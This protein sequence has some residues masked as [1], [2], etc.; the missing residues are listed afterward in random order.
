VKEVQGFRDLKVKK[1][2][3]VFFLSFLQKKKCFLFFKKWVLIDFFFETK[4]KKTLFFLSFLFYF[5]GFF[6]TKR[7]ETKMEGSD[8]RKKR[9]VAH[10]T[11]DGI[12]PDATKHVP[13]LRW[14]RAS[15]HM[16]SDGVHRDGD[17]VRRVAAARR[18][19]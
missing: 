3:S 19:R 1:E 7:E 10:T 16:G 8:G 6:G 17:L 4:K 9:K 11:M 15:N 12:P 14:V 5:I 13:V 2:K 18:A